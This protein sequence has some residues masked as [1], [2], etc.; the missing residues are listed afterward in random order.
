MSMTSV[1]KNLAFVVLIILAIN[2]SSS[3]QIYTKP[4]NSYGTISNRI[5]PDSTFFFPTA[6]GI[7]TDTTSLFSQG[8][9][10][11]AQKMAKAALYYDSCGHKLYIFDPTTKSWSEVTGTGGSVTFQQAI[12]F[13]STFNKD[14]SIDF[15]G[16]D[17]IFANGGFD[18]RDITALYLP[19][20]NFDPGSIEGTMYYKNSGERFRGYVFGGWDNFVMD[21]QLRDSIAA[22]KAQIDTTYYKDLGPNTGG[23]AT[24]RFKGD[25]TLFRM[26]TDTQYVKHDT[27]ANGSIRD[28]LD[29]A[30]LFPAIRATIATS[31]SDA[32]KVPLTRSLTIN[33]TAQDLTADR[34]FNVTDANL[35]TTDITTGNASTTKHGFLP[36][37]PGGTT[38]FLREDGTFAAPPSGG[39]SPGGTDDD[40]QRKSGSSF[41]GTTGL[42][43]WNNTAKRLSVFSTSTTNT[44]LNIVN[45]LSARFVGNNFY[46]GDKSNYQP[47]R[48]LFGGNQGPIDD[49]NMLMSVGWDGH[50]E[51]NWG[52]NFNYE[53]NIHQPFDSAFAIL[54]SYLGYG[55][56]FGFQSVAK[57]TSPHEADGTT[58][59]DVYN[60]IGFV[61]WKIVWLMNGND[62]R[63][64]VTH[65]SQLKLF[66][67]TTSDREMNNGTYAHFHVETATLTM[68]GVPAIQS[69][70]SVRWGFGGNIANYRAATYTDGTYAGTNLYQNYG[71]NSTD[72]MNRYER[73]KIGTT[74]THDIGAGRRIGFEING[75]MAEEGYISTSTTIGD[76]STFE[77]Y[78]K[79]SGTERMRLSQ[80]GYLGIGTSSPAKILD[81]TSTASGVLFP[82]M[83]TTQRDAM[84]AVAYEIIINTDST[85]SPVEIRN[86]ANSAWISIPGSSSGGGG[87]TPNW[88]TV[89][90]QAGSFSASRDYNVNGYGFGLTNAN[91][92]AL[93]ILGTNPGMKFWDVPNN[94]WF[95]VKY[96]SGELTYDGSA[97]TAVRYNKDLR[98]MDAA[99]PN[100]S[101]GANLGAIRAITSN[102]ASL[103]TPFVFWN[104]SSTG[105]GYD[106][107][108]PVD[109]HNAFI[110]DHDGKIGINTAS[111]DS[112]LHVVG[113][114]HFT[115]GMRVDNIA[116]GAGIKALRYNPSNGKFTYVD[117]V[118]IT[119]EFTTTISTSDATPTTAATIATDAGQYQ[120]ITV[121]VI[122][123]AVNQSGTGQYSAQKTRTFGFNG[124]S[125][126]TGR[127][128]HN[129]VAD[130]YETGLS[131]A[132]FTVTTSGTNIIIQFTGEASTNIQAT[133]T[134]KVTKTSFAP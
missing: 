59:R 69:P 38:N 31:G 7:P 30:T 117:T 97:S 16:N 10:G 83:T 78:W 82:R 21:K 57:N 72:L 125:L 116:A 41:A 98:T 126:L 39:G 54:Y 131:T 2:Q 52:M 106:I 130:E 65:T 37:L 105:H 25:T 45:P 44:S 66:D 46:F 32:T 51:F 124:S 70:D 60:A 103:S 84:T 9:S 74:N 119:Q 86:S 42:F 53:N 13:G 89:L 96:T 11:N 61:P 81:I 14:N 121:T 19:W 73:L 63:G 92:T 6:C 24:F 40:V 3:A 120:N 132:T 88:Q 133:F 93:R 68:A 15:D 34:T 128:I 104:N 123:D 12:D 129:I 8:F 33:G 35:S 50:P 17:F 5:S 18:L 112:M 111:P 102:A 29:T 28:Y 26:I 118:P 20:A 114:G 108:A 122:C 76:F 87:G 36:K 99:S 27:A 100:A 115:G 58:L 85:S 67:P 107:L 64:S 47:T 1:L 77:K 110:M 91:D 127:S 22:V 80:N 109:G 95:S 56:G 23:I 71:N 101:Y 62:Y 4:N 55:N 94:I 49:G 79:N 90:Q 75:G 113:G 134:Y 48:I 43:T